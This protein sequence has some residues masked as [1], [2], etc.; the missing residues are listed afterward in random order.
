MGKLEK[1]ITLEEGTKPQP[2]KFIELHGENSNL[3]DLGIHA[4]D[5]SEQEIAAGMEPKWYNV[6]YRKANIDEE[7][8]N[9][10]FNISEGNRK[11]LLLLFY[12]HN[13]VEC[14]NSYI[15]KI[16]ILQA[17]MRL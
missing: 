5:L 14:S 6:E 7:W 16:I 10:D 17:V 15:I 11:R 13:I 3:L 9:R 8:S 1:H 12:C 2:P 4:A